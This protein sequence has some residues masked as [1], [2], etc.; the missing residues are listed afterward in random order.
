VTGQISSTPTTQRTR[1]STESRYS[2]DDVRAAIEI[3][4]SRAEN[5]NSITIQVRATGAFFRFQPIRDPQQPRI[6]C[7]SVR[8]CSS[9]GVLD[10]NGLGWIDRP[11][12]AQ[13]N[14][15]E[16]IEVIRT[17]VGAWLAE[18]ARH[19]LC[20]WV[21]TTEPLATAAQLAGLSDASTT[22]RRAE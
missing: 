22:S 21:L 18:P 10:E 3:S 1:K 14:L 6:W 12:T 8:Q 5:K 13:A 16:M 9:G 17:D 2:A 15:A 19:D 4:P 11:G 7:V 20:R